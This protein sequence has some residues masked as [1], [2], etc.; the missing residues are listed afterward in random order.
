MRIVIATTLCALLGGCGAG[1]LRA[2]AT[3][4]EAARTALDSGA[5]L[6]EDRCSPARS[7]TMDV[8]HAEHER[9][10]ETCIS[11]QSAHGLAIESWVLWA[12]VALDAARERGFDL[13]M[14][15]E[16]AGAL[17]RAYERLS[18]LAR[19]L[20]ADMPSLDLGGAL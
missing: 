16:Y 17:L 9:H 15:I 10:V 3:A 18:E 5:E 13:A 2:H 20:G 1:A 6:I 11:A 7:A 12:S 8:T 4:L 19:S 14:A